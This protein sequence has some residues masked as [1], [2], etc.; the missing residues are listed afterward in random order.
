MAFH[1]EMRAKLS[2]KMKWVRDGIYYM[3]GLMQFLVVACSHL[4]C[5]EYLRINAYYTRR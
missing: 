4:Y 1:G 2:V 3:V 5:G